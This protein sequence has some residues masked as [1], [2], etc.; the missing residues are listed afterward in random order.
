MKFLTGLLFAFAVLAVGLA[1]AWTAA[2]YEYASRP[3]VSAASLERPASSPKPQAVT[4]EPNALS[5]EAGTCVVSAIGKTY[6]WE[7]SCFYLRQIAPEHRRTIAIDV[8]ESEG[9]PPCSNC[10]SVSRT[11][12]TSLNKP[13]AHR[14]A[15]PR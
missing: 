1:L 15:A 2:F 5:L 13:I 6:H 4:V 11:I 10:L 8:A 9:K 3:A 12:S 7:P 14:Q